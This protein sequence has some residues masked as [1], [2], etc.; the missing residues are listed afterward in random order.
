MVISQKSFVN[1]THTKIQNGVVAYEDQ[2]FRPY[3]RFALRLFAPGLFALKHVNF[4]SKLSGSLFIRKLN[5][6]KKMMLLNLET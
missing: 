3:M 5:T 1:C 4:G 2:T 6:E